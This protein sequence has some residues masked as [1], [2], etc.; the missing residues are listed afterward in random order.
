MN[1]LELLGAVAAAQIKSQY[2]T[3]EDTS[4]GQGRLV[5][6]RFNDEEVGAISRAVLADLSLIHI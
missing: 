1:E 5:L 3:G 6:D 2:L 4:E